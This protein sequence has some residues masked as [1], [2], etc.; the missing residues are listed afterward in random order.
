MEQYRDLVALAVAVE[1]VKAALDEVARGR[2]HE[3]PEADIE[4]GLK[5]ADLFGQPREAAAVQARDDV[6][7]RRNA[8][9]EHG[10][11]ATHPGFELIGSHAQPPS[12]FKGRRRSRHRGAH[13]SPLAIKVVSTVPIDR[14]NRRAVY[15]LMARV[16]RCA[17]H[18]D[19]GPGRG[20]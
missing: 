14:L 3:V 4:G 13:R 5:G 20:N 1:H 7:A 11:V 18:P 2:G 10:L 15:P 17:G 19:G 16:L 9:I 8:G 6:E 12:R